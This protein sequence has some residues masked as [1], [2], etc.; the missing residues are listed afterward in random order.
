MTHI[1]LNLCMQLIKIAR[2][3]RKMEKMSTSLCAPLPA[4]GASVLMLASPDTDRRPISADE[5]ATAVQ[6]TICPCWTLLRGRR[7]CAS[8]MATSPTGDCGIK[9][10][11]QLNVLCFLKNCLHSNALRS[12]FCSC[13][14]CNALYNAFHPFAPQTLISLST[15]A[16]R[17]QHKAPSAKSHQLPYLLCHTRDCCL[18]I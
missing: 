7:D 15:I 14:I 12:F 2:A 16:T 8:N 18:T 9:N 4:V 13:L 11:A 5:K 3:S 6:K 17:H 1:C 10:V